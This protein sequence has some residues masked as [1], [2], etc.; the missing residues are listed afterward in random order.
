[1]SSSIEALF[2]E[3]RRFP[4]PREFAAQSNATAELYEQAERD[5]LDVLGGL[6]AH[7]AVEQ[8]VHA[9]ARMERAVREVV[10]RRR[11]QRVGQLSRP[12]RRCRPRRP[13]R[14]LLRGRA[15]RPPDDHL[16]RAARRRQ[17]LRQRLARRSAS[18]RAIASRS[19][20]RWSSSCRWPCWR[21]RGSA[22]PHSVIFGG[23]SPESIVDRVNDAGCVA[24]I[25]ADYGW[26]RGSKVPL[27]RN[28]DIAMEQTPTI[29]HCIVA[30]RSRRRGLHARRARRVVERVRRRPIHAMRT[31]ADERRGPALPPLHERH[32][33]EAQRH[34]AHDGGL[35]HASRR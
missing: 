23:F 21:A 12:A 33:R 27:K 34:Q 4:P 7:A 18:A 28:C 14:L 20:C 25:T 5:Y 13:R 22:P 32:D 17:S 2:E 15:G 31:R 3:G 9:D 16:P 35:S 19:T 29:R 6:G 1:M 8:A 11:A 24:L 30:R 26:R 10:R